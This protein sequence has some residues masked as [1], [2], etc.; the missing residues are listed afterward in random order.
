MARDTTDR[1]GGALAVIADAR[2][3]GNYGQ[4]VAP[5]PGD[6]R[7]PPGQARRSLNPGCAQDTWEH[8]QGV[9]FLPRSREQYDYFRDRARTGQSRRGRGTAPVGRTRS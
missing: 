9:A 7:D 8:C 6:G 5:R 2:W 4:E 3:I 1:D